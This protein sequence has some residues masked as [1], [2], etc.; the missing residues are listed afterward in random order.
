MM[1]IQKILKSCHKT[2]DYLRTDHKIIFFSIMSLLVM[3]NIAS[4]LPKNNSVIGC[5]L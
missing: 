4:I 5:T 2:Q 3:K 1:T